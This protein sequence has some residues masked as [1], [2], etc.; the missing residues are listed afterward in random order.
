MS[1]Y[2]VLIVGGGHGGAQ[3]AMALRQRG[4]TGSLAIVG[5]EPELPY[6]RPPLSKEYLAG[7]KAFE[8]LLIRQP[9]FWA[10]RDVVM[11]G[12]RRVVAVDPAE[13]VV[14]TA[15]GGTIGYD[16]LIWAAGGHARRRVLGHRAGVTIVEAQC[17]A[18]GTAAARGHCG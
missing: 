1:D 12:G 6:E 13:R 2:D 14:T 18:A 17:S 15:D 3:A 9:A 7:E 8:R 11:L 5:E 16:E 10:E 4:F